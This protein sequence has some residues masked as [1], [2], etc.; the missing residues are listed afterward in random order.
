VSG[1]QRG[2]RD[3]ALAQAVRDGLAAVVAVRFFEPAYPNY[4][5]CTKDRLASPEARAAVDKV[6]GD[7]FALWAA[8]NR[9][10]A[11]V[12]FDKIDKNNRSRVPSRHLS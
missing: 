11:A 5:G 8:G 1:L 3:P 10:E 7:A 9:R 12:L 4:A 6:V 2:M